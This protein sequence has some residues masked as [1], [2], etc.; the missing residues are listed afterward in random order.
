MVAGPLAILTGWRAVVNLRRMGRH[1]A[2]G[3]WLILD[4][5]LA[6]ACLNIIFATVNFY[7]YGAYKDMNLLEVA[8]LMVL[9]K[10]IIGLIFGIVIG[11]CLFLVNVVGLKVLKI[12]PQKQLEE[13][14]G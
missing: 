4:V 6:M 9:E 13:K 11:L 5:A 1:V 7:A 12:A 14:G 8:P 3:L 10:I 2:R